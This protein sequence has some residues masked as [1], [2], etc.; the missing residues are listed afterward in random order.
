LQSIDQANGNVVGTSG[1]KIGGIG[2]IYVDD[3]TGAPSWV[4]AK[5]GLFGTSESFVPL[6][7]AS[8]RGSDIQVNYD[9]ATVKDAPRV[10]ADG[11]LSPDEEETLYSYYGLSSTGGYTDNNATTGTTAGT[12]GYTR[13]H[14]NDN[15][16]GLV[17]K[18][19]DKLDGDND[20]DRDLDRRNDHGTVGH[21]TSGPTTDDAM[22]L[23]EE[24]L[25]V[26]TQQR[27]AGRA[28][29]R[30]YVVTENVTQ[31]VPVSHEE[32]RIER[33]PITD[34]NRGAAES[35]PAI[36]EEEHEV[37]LHGEVPVVDKDVEAVERIRLDKETVTEQQTVSDEVRK[38]RVDLDEDGTTNR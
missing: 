1:D 24:R 19:K 2:Q 21:D 34:A 26:G 3:T 30:K 14:D 10:D 32:V 7:G 38:E 5:T 6:E 23:S 17:D 15:D 16:R 20:N 11:A 29:L 4:T 18:V 35:G 36:S 25:N 22:T 33:E 13:D 9:K 28:R 12:A 8:L 37:V 27:E 31:T